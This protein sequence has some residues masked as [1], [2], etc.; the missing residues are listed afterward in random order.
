MLGGLNPLKQHAT[1]IGGGVAGMLAAYHLGDRGFEV[2]LHEK[3]PWLG[4]LIDTTHYSYGIVEQAAHS[5]RASQPVLDL[6]LDIG[7]ELTPLRGSKAAYIFR[8]GTFHR[9]PLSLSELL[10]MLARMIVKPMS[11]EKKNLQE[12]GLRHMGKAATDYL[13]TPMAFGIYGARPSELQIPEAFPR[14]DLE[15]S[16]NLFS[17][18]LEG[19]LKRRGT[20]PMIA[21]KNGMGDFVKKLETALQTMPNVKIHT[22]RDMPFFEPGENRIIAT[23]AYAAAQLIAEEDPYVAS[24]LANITYSPLITVTVFVERE[25]MRHFPGGIGVLIPEVEQIPILG[26][27]FN[28]SSFEGRVS[29]PGIESLTVICGGTPHPELL[30][31]DDNEIEEHVAQALDM[32]FGLKKTP[33]KMHITK[34]EKAIPLYNA[35]LVLAQQRAREGWAALLG[36]VL[37]GNYTGQVSLR[38]MIEDSLHFKE[39]ER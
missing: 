12:F 2:S 26:V 5:L 15:R 37:I 3:G 14:F 17:H 13:L 19:K 35:R 25:S 20:A 18:M 34:W 27:L 11:T 24:L 31:K 9:F 7:V 6:C 10:T 4:G 38:G 21:P 28:S 1:I 23:P 32:L 39:N 30:N 16:R 36:N 33:L 29:D 8:E 22:Q